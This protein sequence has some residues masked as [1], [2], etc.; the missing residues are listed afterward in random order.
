LL[1]GNVPANGQFGGLYR[2]TDSGINFTVR[3]TTP[4]I[5]DGSNTGSGNSSQSWYDLALA[6]SPVNPEEVHVGGINCWKS[7]DGGSNWANTSYWVAT[8]AGLGN[9]THADIHILEYNNSTL[10]CGS[11]GGIFKSTNA[12]EDWSDISS[13]LNISQIYRIGVDPT[14]SN[15]TICG[16]QDNG[17]NNLISGVYNQWFGADGF[18]GFVDYVTPTTIYGE[19]QFGGLLKSTDN[20]QTVMGITPPQGGGGNWLTSFVMDPVDHNTLYSGYSDIWKSKDAGA[21]WLNLTN[22]FKNSSYADFITV[23]PSNNLVIYSIKGGLIRTTNGGTT[24]IDKASSMI[25]K[26]SVSFLAVSPNDANEIWM[27]AS[28]YTVGE[29]VYKSI[30][31]GDTWTNVSGSLPNVSVNC[32]VLQKGTSGVYVGTDV[33]IFYK[34]NSLSDWVL[35]STGLPRTV[36]S[37]LE[38]YYPGNKLRAATYGRGVW[39]SDLVLITNSNLALN[40]PAFSSSNESGS[41]TPNLAVDGNITTRWSSSFS[42]PQWIYVDLMKSY[43]INRVKINWEAAYGKDYKIQVSNDATNW[44]DIKTVAGN[45]LLVNDWTGLLGTGRYVRMLG[46]ARGSQYGYSIYELEVYGTPANNPPTVSITAPKDG[47]SFMAPATISIAANASDSDGNVTKVEFYQGHTKLGEDA[48]APYS[49]DWTA[50]PIGTYTLYALAT[51]NSGN[52]TTSAGVTINVTSSNVNLALNKPAFSS[53]N[54]SNLL[55]A[56]MAVDGNYNTRWSSSF[57]DPQWIY[58]DL[59]KTYAINRVKITWEAAYAKDYLIQFSN[60]ANTWTTI[61]S[62]TGNASLVNDYTSLSGNGRYV[63]IYGTSRAT[64]YGYSIF[65]LEV[66]GT[67]AKA[68]PSVSITSPLDGTSYSVPATVTINAS[69]S[70]SSGNVVKVEFFAGSTKIGEDATAPYSFSWSVQAGGNYILTAKATD[71]NNQSAISAPI[72]IIVF[73]RYGNINLALNKP[74]FSSSNESN[75]LTPN[76]AVDGNLNTRWSSAFSDP[77]WIYVDLGQSYNIKRVGINWEAAYGKNYKIQLSSDANTWTDIITVTGNTSLNNSM[78]DPTGTYGAGR[79]I[80]MLGT[81]RGTQYG[82]SIYEFQVY[83]NP[84]SSPSL[85]RFANPEQPANLQKQQEQKPSIELVNVYPNPIKNDVTIAFNNTEE[86]EVQ[87]QITDLYGKKML[88]FNKPAMRGMNI[89]EIQTQGLVDGIYIIGFY[90]GNDFVSKKKIV[91]RE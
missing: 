53:S 18:E 70:D 87:I 3:S 8:A 6:A 19:Y 11:D 59:G 7:I 21:T 12:A 58:V 42:D 30:N 66:Y 65:E 40:K 71:N 44:I 13:G 28:S 84:I 45:T 39:E 63:R 72:S 34:D 9:Y 46:S 4:N 75:L 48:T 41:L 15:R 55:T 90:A 14:N 33:G 79:Y 17:M 22:G 52:I 31:G 54:E 36:V 25:N 16:A 10:F 83:G 32:I 91:N 43:N 60:D 77:Q 35:F 67:T 80:R 82:Y 86:Q 89:F 81:A 38:I 85:A 62:K 50:V 76:Q 2:S 73:E 56:N 23:A 61:T 27:T 51:D 26:T 68:G 49:F 88:S 57:S 20:G 69:A 5:L 24:W 47:A 1:D 74:A 37:E 64:Q 78:A 29:K